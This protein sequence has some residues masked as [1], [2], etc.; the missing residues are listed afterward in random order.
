VINV[1]ADLDIMV[2]EKMASDLASACVNTW[3]VRHGGA[4]YV[5]AERETLSAIASLV[6]S[7]VYQPEN[8][9]AKRKE[10]I[11]LYVTE[12]EVFQEKTE[13]KGDQVRMRRSSLFLR[14]NRVLRWRRY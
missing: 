7:A 3:I 10:E 9:V 14:Q 6:K 5:P 2:S 8:D 4:H 13:K 12:K 11:K 1:I